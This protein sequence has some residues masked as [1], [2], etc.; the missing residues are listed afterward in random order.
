MQKSIID[1]EGNKVEGMWDG[2]FYKNT[3]DNKTKGF[4]VSLDKKSYNISEEVAINEMSSIIYNQMDL[5]D[6]NAQ[7]LLLKLISERIEGNEEYPDRYEF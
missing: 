1:Y 2:R 5:F 6:V 7:K 4:R 3:E